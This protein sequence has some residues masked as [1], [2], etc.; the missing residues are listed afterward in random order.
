MTGKRRKPAPRAAFIRLACFALLLTTATVVSAQNAAPAPAATQ[1]VKRDYHFE[2]ASIRPGPS[3]LSAPP[4][5]SYT[6]GRFRNPMTTIP[7]LA[8]QAFNKK[9]G[10]ELEYPQWMATTSFAVNAT[11]PDGATKDD[12]P[13]MLQHLLEDRFELKYHHETRQMAGYELVVMKSGSKLVKST[14]PA[15]DPSAANGRGFEIKNGEVQF[16]KDAPSVDMCFTAPGSAACALHGRNRTME[17]LATNLSQK[18]SAPVR[19]ATGLA[20]A[21]DYT[22]T[23]TPEPSSRSGI[24]MSPMP[25]AGAAPAVGDGVPPA[26][27]EHPSLRDALREQLGLELRPVKNVPVDV[28]ILDSASKQPTEN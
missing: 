18:L 20:G 11:I 5:P 21:Y 26:P 15:P 28:V 6:P 8:F 9:Q 2:V 19:D 7:G 12:L 3:S 27:L 10:F 24:V 23:F 16:T 17:I 13:T 14:G 22:L 4:G 1:P 25:P